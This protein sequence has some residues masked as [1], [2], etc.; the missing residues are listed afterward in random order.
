MKTNFKQIKNLIIKLEKKEKELATY[1]AKVSKLEA[2]VQ[3]IQDELTGLLNGTSNEQTN[4]FS[5]YNA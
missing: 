5:T 3:S 4:S 2:E 1:K